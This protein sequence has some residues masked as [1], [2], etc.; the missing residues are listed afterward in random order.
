MADDETKMADGLRDLAT[1]CIGYAKEDAEAIEA[2]DGYHVYDVAEILSPLCE[3]YLAD[4]RELSALRDTLRRVGE[5]AERWRKRAEVRTLAIRYEIANCADDLE[6]TLTP[7]TPEG[8][9]HA[10]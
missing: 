8:E 4:Q 7:A 2:W 6:S 10:E 1:T 3:A 9:A 5:L